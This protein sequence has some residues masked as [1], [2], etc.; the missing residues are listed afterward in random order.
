MVD[1]Q[2]GQ[3]VVPNPQVP[4][5][6]GMMNIIFGGLLLLMGVGYIGLWV[7]MPHYTKQIVDQASKQQ[8]AQKAAARDADRGP[9]KSGG[10]CQDQGRKGEFS[11][12]E[13]EPGEER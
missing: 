1:K 6:F 9:E 10:R 3:W 2:E 11:G 4:R 8:A 13:R 12:S 7:V 5:T